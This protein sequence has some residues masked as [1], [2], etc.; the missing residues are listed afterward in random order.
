MNFGGTFR[1]NQTEKKWVENPLTYMYM[2]A[3][4]RKLISQVIPGMDLD[5]VIPK[6]ILFWLIPTLSPLATHFHTDELNNAYLCHST[7]CWSTTWLLWR[8]LSWWTSKAIII[9]YHFSL[10]HTTCIRT[11]IQSLHPHLSPGCLSVT[12]VSL[13]PT[14]VTC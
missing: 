10:H 8:T 14:K 6:L 12:L 9:N 1:M 5:I 11:H 2:P 3:E 4:N 7:S 13:G